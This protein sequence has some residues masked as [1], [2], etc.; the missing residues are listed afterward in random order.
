MANAALSS[1]PSA[2]TTP[3]NLSLLAPRQSAPSTATD[4]ASVSGKSSAQRKKL[5]SFFVRPG[6]GER[7]RKVSILANFYAVRASEG[8][9]KIIQ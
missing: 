6:Y 5:T 9:G 3:S 2:T 7:G 8:R 4:Y 1:G